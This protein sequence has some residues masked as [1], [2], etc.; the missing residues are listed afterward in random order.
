MLDQE[1]DGG[2]AKLTPS[3]IETLK[4][5]YPEPTPPEMR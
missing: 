4:S 3:V 2:L 1:A 5:L